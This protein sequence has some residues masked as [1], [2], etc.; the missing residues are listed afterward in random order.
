[1]NS[2]K[3]WFCDEIFRKIRFFDWSR[4]CFWSKIDQMFCY[5]TQK[6]CKAAHFDFKLNFYRELNKIMEYELTPSM[7]IMSQLK[8][9]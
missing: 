7:N 3:M 4:E 8:N 5:K 2:R 9:K 1:M 6:T